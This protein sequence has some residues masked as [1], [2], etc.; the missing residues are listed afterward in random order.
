VKRKN[1]ATDDRSKKQKEV[2]TKV[3]GKSGAAAFKEIWVVRDLIALYINLLTYSQIRPGGEPK[4]SES[5]IFL[6]P[7]YSSTFIHH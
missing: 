7:F 2:T 6:N 4:Q 1:I 5:L 3:A